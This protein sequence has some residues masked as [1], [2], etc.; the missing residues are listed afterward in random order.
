M[1]AARRLIQDGKRPERT[2]RVVFFT[3]EEFGGQ[4]GHAYLEA[5]RHELDRYV[6]ALESDSG[7][8]EPNGFSVRGDSLA[9]VHVAAL[10]APLGPLGASEVRPGWA[11]VDIGPLV[12]EGVPGVGHRVSGDYFHYHHSPADTFDKIDSE[13]MA[14]NV[15]AITHL[16][17]ALADEPVPLRDR[18]SPNAPASTQ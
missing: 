14:R 18:I 11:G 15:A 17:R 8:F 9:V 4:G 6:A 13:L 3:S 10:A 2:V 1:A 16:V 12:E 5:H 7:C